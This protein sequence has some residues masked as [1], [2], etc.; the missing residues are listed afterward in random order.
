MSPKSSLNSIGIH[1]PIS[2]KKVYYNISKSVFSCWPCFLLILHSKNNK[3]KIFVI[4][5]LGCVGLC[6]KMGAIPGSPVS[7]HINI[8]HFFTYWPINIL[9]GYNHSIT[10]KF[11]KIKYFWPFLLILSVTLTE[12]DFGCN[13]KILLF[14]CLLLTVSLDKAQYFHHYLSTTLPSSLH[15]TTT[16]R[17]GLS[18]K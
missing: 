3:K 11:S 2:S 7:K 8:F 4:Y 6:M 14:S 13:L 9:P 18:L 12:T 1:H 15:F 5:L 17:Y 10:I 16:N